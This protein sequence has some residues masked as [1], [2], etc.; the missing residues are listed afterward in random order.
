MQYVQ[1]DREIKK[2]AYQFKKIMEFEY[3]N[4]QIRNIIEE[5]IHSERD[6]E[7]MKRRLIDG[8]TYEKLSEEFSLS[9]TQIKNICYKNINLCFH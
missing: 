8:I 2:L 7:I 3:T 1:G 5:K 9:V 6:R 4:S